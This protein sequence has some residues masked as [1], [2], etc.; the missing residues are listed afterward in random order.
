MPQN[1]PPATARASAPSAAELADEFGRTA[2]VLGGRLAE[3]LTPH[4]LSMP[5]FSLLVALDRSGPS[6]IT[7]L[8]ERVG[9]SQGTASALV[10]SL[11][12][13][14]L[15]ERHADADDARATRLAITSAG[16][17]KA[18]AWRADYERAAE[19]VFASIS[20]RQRTTLVELLQAL[21]R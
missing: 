14:G 19:Q 5:R 17:S 16:R 6:R 18:R 12:R 13:D 2:K 21:G 11:V 9:I 15:V 4:G 20:P 8:G 3:Q 7:R 1:E 10:E